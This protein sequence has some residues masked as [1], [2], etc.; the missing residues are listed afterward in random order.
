MIDPR[1]QGL[2]PGSVY[3]NNVWNV[4]H[5][6]PYQSRPLSRDYTIDVMKLVLG[7]I[8]GQ[9]RCDAPLSNRLQFDHARAVVRDEKEMT[10]EVPVQGMPVKR[11][12]KEK[13]IS[14]LSEMDDQPEH[15]IG[16]LFTPTR[17]DLHLPS[18]TCSF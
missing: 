4:D 11:Q 13:L 12:E 6:N 1:Q 9:G 17:S 14:R 5:Q 16:E 2:F 8:L 10:V 15:N 7:M 18:S 3:I